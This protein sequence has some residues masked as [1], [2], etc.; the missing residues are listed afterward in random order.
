MEAGKGETKRKMGKK[1]D[2]F[3]LMQPS[4]WKLTTLRGPAS[5]VVQ[6]VPLAG[7]R[8]S[9]RYADGSCVS[10]DSKTEQ[11]LA[12]ETPLKAATSSTQ[13]SPTLTLRTTGNNLQLLDNNNIVLA[14]CGLM[15][16][17]S[18][19]PSF[20]SGLAVLPGS[21]AA[22]YTVVTQAPFAV[23]YKAVLGDSPANVAHIS[24][25]RIVTGHQGL[26]CTGSCYC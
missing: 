12:D 5:H 21:R 15:Y 24:G 9:V 22:L 6:M 11:T 20:D 2:R 1:I 4:D 16:P 19:A 23:T 18:A 13:I 10:W 3:A 8:V 26:V 25:R 17:S 14:S 7:R